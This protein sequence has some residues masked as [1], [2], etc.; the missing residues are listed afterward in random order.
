MIE[1]AGSRSRL[2]DLQPLNIGNRRPKKAESPK[3]TLLASSPPPIKSA[4][5]S[6][7]LIDDA[8][9]EQMISQVDSILAQ[10]EET[11]VEDVDV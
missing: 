3:V 10:A 8:S 6:S 11:K 7:G 4:R 5:N 1:E 9:I 2:C